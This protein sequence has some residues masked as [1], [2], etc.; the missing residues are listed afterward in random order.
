[1]SI[2]KI[3]QNLEKDL[4]SMFDSEQFAAKMAELKE[5]E[6]D[7]EYQ[8]KVVVT[9]EWV[10]RDWEVIKA[11]WIEFKNYRKNPVVLVDHS[12]K[13]DSIVWKTLKIYQEKWVTYAEWVF[14]KGIEKA[15]LIRTLYNQWFVKTVSIWFIAK[16]RDDKDKTTITKSEMLEFSFVAVP[17][18]PE[19]L[20]LDGKTYQ[21]CLDLWILK[22][23]TSENVKAE[24][25]KVWDMVTYRNIERW[26]RED[27]TEVE[28]IYPS[29]KQ[30]PRMWKV[31]QKFDNW[32]E[33]LTWWDEALVASKE[34]PIFTIHDH[35]RS[36]DWPKTRTSRINMS[37]Y[38]DMKIEKIVTVEEFE[39]GFK[40]YLNKTQV[41][42]K[43]LLNIIKV[44]RDEVSEMKSQIKTFAEDKAKWKTLEESRKDAQD[45]VK[46]LS[47]YLEK[48]KTSAK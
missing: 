25:L 20:S 42:L 10:D 15:E 34:N 38:S 23:F 14:A 24:D 29:E 28:N 8:F 18:N 31:I 9:T 26:T 4:K 40:E 44:L 6:D 37:K 39:K 13:I 35:I 43:D 19:A 16:Q 1:M 45:L 41:D 3:E 36:E 22:E 48:T 7:K 47:A 11:D 27:W 21:K 46:G 12:Y 2:K 33:I 17:A 5:I 32:E 30:L